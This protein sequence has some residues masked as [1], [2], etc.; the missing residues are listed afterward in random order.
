MKV[1]DLTIVSLSGGIP[2]VSAEKQIIRSDM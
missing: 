1:K 2:G